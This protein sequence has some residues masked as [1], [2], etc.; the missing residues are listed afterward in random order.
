[1]VAFFIIATKEKYPEPC[2]SRLDPYI[3]HTIEIE[4]STARPNALK[5]PTVLS[6]RLLRLISKTEQK[7]LKG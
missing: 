4:H 6:Q 5:F 2:Q 1:M 7:P 3:L